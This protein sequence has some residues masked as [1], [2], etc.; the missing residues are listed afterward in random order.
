MK[1]HILLTN[2]KFFILRFAVIRNFRTQLSIYQTPT[3]FN[4]SVTVVPS[5]MQ[6]TYAP[7]GSRKWALVQ[8]PNYGLGNPSIG[9]WFQVERRISLFRRLQTVS[10][11]CPTGGGG[12]LLH[13][14][15]AREWHWSLTPSSIDGCE[16]TLCIH[17]PAKVHSF[18]MSAY[19]WF[20]LRFCINVF[21]IRA[22]CPT[23][24]NIITLA[25]YAR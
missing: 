18:V 1:F 8:W 22:T 10:E 9:V 20:I 11:V 15:A 4:S 25:V 7:H 19:F 14:K 2:S 3:Q 12:S 17:K 13:D 6:I 24:Y 23:H 16:L 21:P 5:P